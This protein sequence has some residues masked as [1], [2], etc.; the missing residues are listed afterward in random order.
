M[1]DADDRLDP[2]NLKR[3]L[4]G[5][6]G[7][8]GL[9]QQVQ[10]RITTLYRTPRPSHPRG[11]VIGGGRSGGL[12]EDT[13]PAELRDFLVDWLGDDT[14]TT[15][16]TSEDTLHNL[17]SKA[18]GRAGRWL[19]RRHVSNRDRQAILELALRY[20]VWLRT[21]CDH[22]HRPSGA[23]ECPDCGLVEIGGR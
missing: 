22:R 11:S 21:A 4:F 20:L 12:G 8:T 23:Q 7:M 14:V 9:A 18:N 5:A 17:V 16:D 2:V 13:D 6:P 10:E 19:R 1:T 15:A 3:M